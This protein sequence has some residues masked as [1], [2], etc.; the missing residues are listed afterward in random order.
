VRGGC[1]ICHGI[2]EIKSANK[3]VVGKLKVYDIVWGGV[4]VGIDGRIMFKLI[5]KEHTVECTVVSYH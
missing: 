4:A 2:G 3:T 5:L 1:D